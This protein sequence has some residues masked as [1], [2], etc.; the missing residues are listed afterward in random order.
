MHEGEVL[1]HGPPQEFRERSRG[2]TY[3]VTSSAANKRALQES[4]STAPGVVD[5]LIQ[6]ES[7]R[8]VMESDVRPDPA[9]LLPDNKGIVIQAGAAPAGRQLCDNAAQAAARSARR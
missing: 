5:A 3:L 6:G 1:G 9:K 8:L 4:L 2:R 7:V